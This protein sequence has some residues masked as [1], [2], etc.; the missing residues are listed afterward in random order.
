MQTGYDEENK[1]HIATLI[2]DIINDMKH[3]ASQLGLD[4]KED[5]EDSLDELRIKI[6]MNFSYPLIQKSLI[7]VFPNYQGN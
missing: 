7:K 3:K 5:D 2:V 6:L 1:C 4:E